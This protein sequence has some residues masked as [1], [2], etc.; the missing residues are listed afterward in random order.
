M[1][2]YSNDLLNIAIAIYLIIIPILK[3]MMASNKDFAVKIHG[4]KIILGVLVLL[5]GGLIFKAFFILIG[6]L[7]ILAAIFV[8]Y[9]IIC[10]KDYSFETFKTSYTNARMSFKKN[11][12]DIIDADFK[13]KDENND[14]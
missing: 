4:Y 2:M 5:L 7:I 11:N 1:I 14:E 13:E 10:E 12:D 9:A 8:L 3:I 6:I